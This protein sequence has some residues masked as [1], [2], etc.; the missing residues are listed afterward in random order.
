MVESY[1]KVGE[2]YENFCTHQDYFRVE[3]DENGFIMI[4]SMCGITDKEKQD[5]KTDSSFEIRFTIIASVCFFAFR[6]GQMPWS[7]CPFHPALYK[8]K[9]KFPHF[10]DEE[11]FGLP[12]LLFDSSTGELVY[13]RLLGLGHDFSVELA[14]WAMAANEE[15]MDY[16][17]YEHIIDEVYKSYSSAD[18]AE[19][20]TSRY[21]LR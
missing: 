3:Y 6:F 4:A 10:A 9:R 5:F 1:Y 7:D 16:L 17:T 19:L 2:R 18:L 14:N 13:F 12:V 21:E 15:Q 20:A 8:E 11:G